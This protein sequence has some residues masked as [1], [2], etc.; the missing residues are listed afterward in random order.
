MRLHLYP[1]QWVKIMFARLLLYDVK[2]GFRLESEAT[3]LSDDR[4]RLSQ[5]EIIVNE[6]QQSRFVRIFSTQGR[7]M[8]A[9]LENIPS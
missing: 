2:S 5:D 3:L 7:S 4:F 8:S 9:A 1:K 6:Q